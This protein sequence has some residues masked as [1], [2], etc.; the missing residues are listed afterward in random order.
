MDIAA[1]LSSKPTATTQSLTNLAAAYRAQKYLVYAPWKEG[2]TTFATSTVEFLKK[3]G[4]PPEKALI[5]WLDNDDGLQPLLEKGVIDPLFYPSIHY[6]LN[7]N[8]DDLEKESK[9]W[10]PKLIEN[11][12]KNGPE[13]SWIIVDNMKSAWEWARDKY[14]MDLYG[15][16]EHEYAIQ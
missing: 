3:K 1:A 12:K 6:K 14:A 15:M 16:H 7:S 9:E 4:V 8:F 13:T 10:L 5:L 11:Q 2:K